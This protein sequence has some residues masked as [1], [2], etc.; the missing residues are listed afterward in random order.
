[1]TVAASRPRAAVAALLRRRP[2]RRFLL[3]QTLSAFGDSLMPVALVFAVLGQGGN[4]G[5]VGLVLLASRVP[6]IFVV[7]L[8]G[9][10]GDSFDQRKIM[11]V[12]DA[13]RCALQATTGVLLIGGHAALWT[14]VALQALA[15]TA[16]ALFG[17]AAASLL[18]RLVP[19]EEVT[20]ANAL[21]G[22]TRNIVGVSGL[23][24][25]GVLVATA[26]PGW[27]F[28]VDSATFAA[29][30][31]FLLGVAATREQ[32]PS[33]ESLLRMVVSG[34][35]EAFARQWVWTSILYVAAL[36]V[37]A[38]CPFLVLG[39]VVANE[40]GGPGAWTAIAVGYAVGGMGGNA[41]GLRWR[42]SRP[43][44]TAFAGAFALS[45]LLFL[46]ALAAPVPALAL[47][48]ILAGVQ[49]SIF[50]LLHN[51]TLQTNIPAPFVARVS[52]V[53]MLGSL[54]VV[55]AGLGLVGP[56]SD[57]TSPRA[58]LVAA[59]CSA[60]IATVAVLLVP[61][62]RHLRAAT[63]QAFIGRPTALNAA[64]DS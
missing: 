30:A 64:T 12:A 60:V 2:V 38:V 48:A 32:R 45:P 49:A 8:G 61:E 22:L 25:S 59:A 40:L 1:M 41:V 43:L 11:V 62:V 15:G 18:P 33:A 7:L 58:V 10:V 21:A 55:P 50:N 26:G 54:V 56:I 35:G 37:V 36:N 53:N 9:A 16:S 42:P 20:A 17:P 5:D 27:A 23:A 4:A 47:A 3:G 39:P 34:L 28:L 63:D 19:G 24:V 14:L 52:S 46:L 57:A 31:A 51:T 13:A 29:S 44:R 6:T